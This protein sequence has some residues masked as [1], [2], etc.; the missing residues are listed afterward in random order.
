MKL[1]QTNST[2]STESQISAHLRACFPNSTLEYPIISKIKHYK[3][4]PQA[5]DEC[6]PLN[7][8]DF[9]PKLEGLLLFFK[10]HIFLKVYLFILKQRERQR[11]REKIP[12]RL[13][14]GST[15]PDAGLELTNHEIMP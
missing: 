9:F 14:T 13:C 3:D 11:G 1:Y 6:G 7:F 10:V 5:E 8:N 15:E 4:H 12:S 2:R